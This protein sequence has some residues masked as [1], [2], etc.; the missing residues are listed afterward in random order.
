MQLYNNI[1]NV[2]TTDGRILSY[3]EKDCLGLILIDAMEK[4][5]EIN[6]EFNYSKDFL[7]RINTFI[8]NG[9]VVFLSTSYQ[10]IYEGF[11]FI[12]D[13]IN[14]LQYNILN[15]ID[16]SMGS[17]YVTKNNEEYGDTENFNINDYINFEKAR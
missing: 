12:P 1:I 4:F 14:D 15:N 3:G 13:K 2:I 6:K 9:H 8:E 7:E 16:F 5:L 17:V 11:I 10:H